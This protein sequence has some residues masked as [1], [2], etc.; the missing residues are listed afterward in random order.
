MQK[1]LFALLC[2]LFVVACTQ[3]ATQP[4]TDTPVPSTPAE[5]V[6]ETPAETVEPAQ[7]A[8]TLGEYYMT[9]STITLKEGSTVT[10]TITNEGDTAH[11]FGLL[12]FGVNEEVQPGE[13]KTATFVANKKGSFRVICTVPCGSGHRTMSTT[14]TVE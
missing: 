5:T 7:V 6:T 3:T 1:I 4:T 8:V 2:A 9:P 12:E 13:T 11:G 14:V 10:L